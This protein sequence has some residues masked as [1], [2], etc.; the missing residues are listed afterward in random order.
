[1]TG[2]LWDFNAVLLGSW[3]QGDHGK[4]Q[5]RRKEKDKDEEAET[6]KSGQKTNTGAGDMRAGV[7]TPSIHISVGWVWW[8]AYNPST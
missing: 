6:L 2:N 5:Q 1:M 3:I 7:W 8:P 4:E